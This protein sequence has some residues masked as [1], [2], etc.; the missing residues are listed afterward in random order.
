MADEHPAFDHL[1]GTVRQLREPGGCPWDRK[2]THAS[3]A[4][5]M[6]EE[7]YEA[8]DAM[9]GA[10]ASPE[11]Q[12]HLCEELGDVLYQVV[13]N[14]QIASEEGDFTVED[15]CRGIDEKLVRRHPH[16]FGDVHADTP[17]EVRDIWA[18]VKREERE[19]RE[20]A[21]SHKDGR[22][23]SGLLDSVPTAMPALMQCQKISAR[24]AKI[25]FEWD[26]VSGVWEK[27][28]EERSEFEAEAPGTP[29]RELEFGDLLFALVNVARL[30]GIDAE[31]ALARSNQKFRSRWSRMEHMASENGV[32][33]ENLSTAELNEWWDRAKAEEKRASG[34]D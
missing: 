4:R 2:Q 17:E 20:G 26:D 32:K 9:S 3:L 5:Y 14:A 22:D 16:V 29:S 6:I 31:R 24:A 1:V 11:S 21:A 23:T 8:A 28:A 19:E 12:A 27:V 7:A 18:E 13:L 15:V 34:S 30:E 10:P 33:L 25:G